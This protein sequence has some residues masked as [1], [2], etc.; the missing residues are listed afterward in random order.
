MSGMGYKTPKAHGLGE[1]LHRSPPQGLRFA[2]IASLKQ[3]SERPKE[4][5][6]RMTQRSG[7]HEALLVMI[8]HFGERKIRHC[9]NDDDRISVPCFAIPFKDARSLFLLFNNRESNYLEAFAFRVKNDSHTN[10]GDAMLH[11]STSPTANRL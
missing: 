5:R 3:I 6:K 11:K 8:K 2:G 7:G 9:K 1:H 10:F 4:P